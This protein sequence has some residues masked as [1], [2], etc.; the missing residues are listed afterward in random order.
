MHGY[1]AVKAAGLYDVQ[2]RL[3]HPT[4][5]LISGGY[6]AVGPTPRPLGLRKPV[7]TTSSLLP[8]AA[9]FDRPVW[10][11]FGAADEI[12]VPVRIGLETGGVR[13]SASADHDVVIKSLIKIS[14]AVLVVIVQ[15]LI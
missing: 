15:Q 9:T 2:P 6:D 5:L 3:R 7:A 8:S 1:E 14:L 11:A 10:R 4:A 12:K 13:V